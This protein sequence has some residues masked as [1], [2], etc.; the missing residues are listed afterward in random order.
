MFVDCSICVQFQIIFSTR[1]TKECLHFVRIHFKLNLLLFTT[2]AYST[3]KYEI[4]VKSQI[5]QNF[6]KST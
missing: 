6:N 5:C 3:S 1:S 2:T 4:R